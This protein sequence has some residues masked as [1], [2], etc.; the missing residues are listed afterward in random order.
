MSQQRCLS[1]YLFWVQA[2]CTDKRYMVNRTIYSPEMR[3]LT[4]W[5]REQRERQGLTMRTL[6]DR[7]GKPHSFVQ[8]VEQG[9]RRLDVVEYLWYCSALGAPPKAPLAT[10]NSP[11]S[12]RSNSPRQDS[13]I[14]N[15][16]CC[17]AQ[18]A[19]QLL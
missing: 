1:L 5:L 12:G 7:L 13:Q 9:E 6:A 16:R 11:T 8:K 15:H 17:C 18:G 14:I 2:P 3:T 4:T 10:S 19:Q